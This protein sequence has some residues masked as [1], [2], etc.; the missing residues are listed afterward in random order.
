[1]QQQVIESSPPTTIPQ[2]FL[3]DITSPGLR[4]LTTTTQQRAIEAAVVDTA[5]T[6]TDTTPPD[7][8]LVGAEVFYVL[9]GGHSQGQR[10]P[11]TVVRDWRNGMVNLQ[12]FTDATNDYPSGT[13][14]SNGTLWATSVHYAPA[15]SKQI[16]T[17]HWRTEL[18]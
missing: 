2:G 17:W 6:Q 12:V 5:I 8:D 7:R 9:T 11:A 14:G 1:M 18:F 10:R 15:A 4:A 13:P 16:G 3:T